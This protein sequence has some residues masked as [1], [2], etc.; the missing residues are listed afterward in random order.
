MKKNKI[1]KIEKAYCILTVTKTGFEFSY[2]GTDI[3]R[4]VD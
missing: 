3:A 4:N 2:S 1:I